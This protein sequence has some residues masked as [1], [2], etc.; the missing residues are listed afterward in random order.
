MACIIHNPISFLGC[1]HLPMPLHF[2]G[3]L[4]K[5]S[6]STMRIHPF[7]LIGRPAGVQNWVILQLMACRLFGAKP[8]PWPI[9]MCHHSGHS[10]RLQPFLFKKMHVCKMSAISF[11]P[12]LVNILA[13]TGCGSFRLFTVSLQSPN[14]M[15]ISWSARREPMPSEKK[16]EIPIGHILP[17]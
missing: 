12:R 10:K 6:I 2:N 9:S 16:V 5:P 14:G 15:Q 1:N 11:R 17:Q 7:V 3:D 8:L 13:A 4:D